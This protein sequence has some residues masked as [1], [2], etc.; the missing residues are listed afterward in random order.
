MAF[1][2]N[3]MPLVDAGLINLIPDPWTFDY[4]L[5]R[6]HALKVAYAHMPM[7]IEHFRVQR[8]ALATMPYQFR[9]QAWAIQYIIMVKYLISLATECTKC[10]SLYTLH[11]VNGSRKAQAVTS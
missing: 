5:R 3:V 7:L 10:G 1:F 9:R 6:Y 11:P 2:L 4:H 8:N